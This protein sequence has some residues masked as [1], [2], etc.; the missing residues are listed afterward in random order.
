MSRA[1]LRG[2]SGRRRSSAARALGVDRVPRRVMQAEAVD[3]RP[4]GEVALRN[5]LAVGRVRGAPGRLPRFRHLP[6][7]TVAV[8]AEVQHLAGS[9]GGAAVAA[10]HLPQA[11]VA[12]EGV[13]RDEEV[14]G[15]VYWEVGNGP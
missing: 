7:P 5:P 8:P 1:G 9:V 15:V 10:D 3:V 6:Q 14:E 4:A 12:A 11:I 13:L 2:G